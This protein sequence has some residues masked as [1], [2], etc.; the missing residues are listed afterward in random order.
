VIED[1]AGAT[2]FA[3]SSERFSVQRAWRAALIVDERGS[4]DALLGLPS[5]SEKRLMVDALRETV[6]A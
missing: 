3:R 1:F 6:A 4:G 2:R 5:G